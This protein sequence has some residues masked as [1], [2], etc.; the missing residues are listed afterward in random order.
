MRIILPLRRGNGD[1]I[2]DRAGLSC[3]K[4]MRTGNKTRIVA[5]LAI[6]LFAGGL[7]VTPVMAFHSRTTDLDMQVSHTDPPTGGYDTW[8]IT[9]RHIGESDLTNVWIYLEL[10]E[11]QLEWG[12]IPRLRPGE[13]GDPINVNVIGGPSTVTI[14]WEWDDH[15]TRR[16]R[17]STSLPSIRY[18]EFGGISIGTLPL[19]VRLAK[20]TTPEDSPSDSPL[21]PILVTALLAAAGTGGVMVLTYSRRRRRGSV[22][23]RGLQ[24]ALLSAL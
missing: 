4:T 18:A 17:C 9:T 6:T 24:K 2:A 16:R 8:T 15:E 13:S 20:E 21:N 11:K 12:P 14:C 7:M 3:R 1:N 10:E 22:V 23:A 5:S 19:E